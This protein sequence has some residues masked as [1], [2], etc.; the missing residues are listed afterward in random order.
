MFAGWRKSK[1]HRHGL[2]SRKSS[3]AWCSY[4]SLPV[5]TEPSFLSFAAHGAPRRGSAACCLPSPSPVP[6]LLLPGGNVISFPHGETFQLPEGVRYH[7]SCGEWLLLSR[8]GTSC[9]SMNPFTKA[10]MLLSSSR[11]VEYSIL[12]VMSELSTVRYVRAFG[13]WI[14]GTRASSVNVELLWRSSGWAAAVASTPGSRTQAA[15][16]GGFLGLR[17][18]I[19]E[20]DGG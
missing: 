17:H 20:A 2:T 9:F 16:K 3:S 13:L 10:T 6:W 11:N 18:K 12:P 8:D 1:D 5:P 7:N 4:A 14:A 19:K 15:T